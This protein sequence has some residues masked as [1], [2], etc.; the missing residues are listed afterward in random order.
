MILTSRHTA[1]ICDSSMQVSV[2][3]SVRGPPFKYSITTHN[4]S[5]LYWFLL[6]IKLKKLSSLVQFD[7]CIGNYYYVFKTN[8]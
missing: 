1:A 7:K 2:T 6:K 5:P 4:S 8:F 3:T